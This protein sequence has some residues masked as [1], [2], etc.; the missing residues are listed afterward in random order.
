MQNLGPLARVRPRWRTGRRVLIVA[1]TA[2]LA[3]TGLTSAA[4]AT[5]AGHVTSTAHPAGIQWGK[6]ADPGLTNAGAVCGFVTVP[7]DYDHPRGATI[8]IAVSMVA[9]TVP[10]SQYQGVMLVNPGGP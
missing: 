6:C 1:L 8:Q 10:D 4:Q 5:S 3:V 2:M 7:L 9:H